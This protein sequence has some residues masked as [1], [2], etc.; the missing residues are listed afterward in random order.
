MKDWNQLIPRERLARSA[1]AWG[2]VLPAIAAAA[3]AAVIM[4]IFMV[5][6]FSGELR[7]LLGL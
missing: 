2:V 3:S 4:A 6:R 1:L 5:P 7:Q